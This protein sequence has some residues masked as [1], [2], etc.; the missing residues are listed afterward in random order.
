M[1]GRRRSWLWVP[2][3]LVLLFGG[4]V[5]AG[6]TLLPGL[7]RSKGQAWV[8]TNLPGKQLTLGAIAFDPWTLTLSIAD[9]AIADARAPQAP[10]VAIKALT[11]DASLSSLWNGYARRDAVTVTTPMVDAVLRR[12]GSRNLAELVPVDD[13]TPTPEVWIGD[14]AGSAGT[15]RFTDARRAAAHVRTLAPVHFTLHDFATRAA[16]GGGFRLTATS[17]AGEGF[18]W[19][20]TLAMA[21]LAS[22]GRFRITAL[23]LATIGRFAGD[24]LPVALTGGRVDLA[25]RYQAALPAAMKGAAA[26][27]PQVTA[28]LEALT[29]TDVA[30]SVGGD[31]I[32]LRRLALAPTQLSTAGDRLAL[33]AVAIAGVTVARA[34]GERAA[35]AGLTLAASRYT[36]SSG[37]A[38]IG[39][40]GLQGLS[41]TGRGKG[42]ETVA[43]AA[44]AVAP[45]RIDT[46]PRTAAIGAISAS[47]L[48]LGARIGAD[49]SISI[50]GLYPMALPAAAP[51]AGPAWQPALAGFA[52]QDAAVRVTVARPR[53]A[54]GATFD[55]ADLA[56]RVGPV[57][58]TLDQPVTIAA[59]TRLNGK[60][61]LKVSGSADPGT[62]TADLA[63]D[64]SRLPLADLAALAPPAAVQLKAGT[65]DV[66]GRLRIANG[67]AG[68]APDFAGSLAVADLDLVQRAD[69]SA[70][71]GWKRLDVSGIRYTA[72]PQRL[73]IVRAS[74][75]RAN[76]HVILTRESKLNLATVAGAETPSLAAP[77]AP[78]AETTTRI[79]VV[80]PVSNSLDA[81]GQLFPIRIGEVRI[82]N[83]I[84]GFEDFSIEPNFAASIQG[85]SGSVTGLSTDRGS[86]ARFN[87]K[88]YVVDR[89]APVSITGRANVFAYDADTDLTAS[90]KNIELPV[91]N[92]YSGRFAGYAIAKG[93]LS[94][95]IHYRIV[96]RGLQ[97]EHNVVFDQLTWG[98]ATESKD[99]VSLPIRLATSL[100]KDRN[101]VIN[102][103]LP[104]GG[105]LDDPKFR[106]WPVVWQIVGNVFTKLIT[107]PFALIGSLF[108]GGDK[109]QFVAFAPGS[110]QL[111]PEAD[112]SLKALAKG[113]AERPE[114]NLDI[115]A[116]PGL[117][118][119]AEAMTT[120]RLQAAALAG[121]KGPIAADYATLAA[122]KKADQLKSLY[123]AK[124]GKG[125]K[126]PD[127]LPRAG[128]LAGGEAKAAA[129]TAEIT[130]LESAL[131]P[132]FAPSD[133]EL[134]ALGQARADAVKQA[135]LGDDGLDPARVFVS[136]ALG[137]KAKDATIEMELKVK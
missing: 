52:L 96:N 72:R 66:K 120:T 48:R 108:G 123:K 42:A 71:V 97:A 1:R 131:R 21:P 126:F 118:E 57:A 40:A 128:M 49:N 8:E 73:S 74:F 100:L 132:K 50:P 135:L 136:T 95:T 109:A 112:A 25:G 81:A 110:A 6:Y 93:K 114:V 119:D 43:L 103:D 133:A 12:D 17:D 9:I 3:L 35:L 45:S 55:L 70:L 130:W 134:A 13:G 51:G 14:L 20:G 85:F 83:S 39:A 91:F 4:A 15:L 37:V 75:D 68:P 31:R 67:R 36:L 34:S 65:L 22:T 2:A 23:Q 16:A 111:P 92:P 64:I 122:D 78:P 107:A 102:L 27:A 56:V 105:T 127:D 63:L 24:L 47:G 61:R 38:E 58:G 115:P 116:G 53:P 88:G 98:Q 5:L 104:V 62:A 41:L 60:A 99:K 46:T 79:K 89:F 82:T 19:D 59:A 18:A 129:R 11:V 125:P 44:L 77:D 28:D 7:V 80:A 113:L 117:R 137:V 101:G 121:R 10:L 76:S 90:F 86:Q 94:T 32:G 84:I 33:G 54:Q 69:G 87:L 29:L 124:F 30:A 26:P 106:I